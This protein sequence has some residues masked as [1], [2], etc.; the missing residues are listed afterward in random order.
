[1][2]LLRK[3]A[4][5]KIRRRKINKKILGVIVI[6]LFIIVITLTL[7]NLEESDYVN[8]EEGDDREMYS[9]QLP[10]LDSTGISL[11]MKGDIQPYSSFADDFF[12]NESSLATEINLWGSFSNDVLP[13]GGVDS[14]TFQ[15]IIHEDNNKPGSSRWEKTFSPGEYLVTLYEESYHSWYC[16]WSEVF[17]QN[18]HKKIYQYDFFIEEGIDFFQKNTEIYWLE[19]RLIHGDIDY[20][21]GWKTTR[22][23]DRWNENA[24]SFDGSNWMPLTY[25]S[26]HEYYNQKINLAFAIH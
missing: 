12:W 24:Y 22:D 23:E 17:N 5:Q 1:M 15:I 2:N 20:G 8:L 19:V 4:Q 9:S 25:P 7:V 3:R 16:S 14:L 10:D 13:K 18:N 6:I 11:C 26:G 21:F